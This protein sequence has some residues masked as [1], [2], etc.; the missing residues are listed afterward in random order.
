[1]TD[2]RDGVLWTV[3]P[4]KI[5]L[6][7][8]NQ[9]I[10]EHHPHHMYKVYS[11]VFSSRNFGDYEFFF[12]DKLSEFLKSAKVYFFH[13]K[14]SGKKMKSLQNRLNPFYP[15]LSKL[16]TKINT[17]PCPT[18]KMYTSFINKIMI[19]TI[20]NAAVNMYHHLNKN[21]FQPTDFVNPR[22]V[23]RQFYICWSGLTSFLLID[24]ENNEIRIW[25]KFL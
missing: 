11:F 1:M 8:L 4:R 7:W 22:T 6:G 18:S 23:S 19:R 2:F 21:F 16:R 24:G 15:F 10:S 25:N 13:S 3:V 5:T 12:S 9:T 14:R 20:N 17:S